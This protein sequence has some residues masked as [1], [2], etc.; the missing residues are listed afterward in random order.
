MITKEEAYEILLNSGIGLKGEPYEH[1]DEDGEIE[2]RRRKIYD[3][4]HYGCGGDK[5]YGFL[6]F[7]YGEKTPPRINGI[8]VIFVD[9]ET[10]EINDRVTA[11]AGSELYKKHPDWDWED[12]LKV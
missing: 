4:T 12:I 1:E 3:A 5:D 7:D 9:K 10:G 6:T 8:F 2:I 11:P